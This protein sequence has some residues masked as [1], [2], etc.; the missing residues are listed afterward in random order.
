HFLK[1]IVMLIAVGI[2]E[3]NA[4]TEQK[5]ANNS[6]PTL[7]HRTMEWEP[8]QQVSDVMHINSVHLYGLS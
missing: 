6:L 8:V 5:Q 7:D 1:N 3:L 4:E 2:Q